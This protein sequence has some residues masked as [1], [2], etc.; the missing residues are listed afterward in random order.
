MASEWANVKT[1]IY[2][3][4]NNPGGRTAE[5]FLTGPFGF[6]DQILQMA[7]YTGV[8]AASPLDR[9][10]TA[11]NATNSGQLHT[12]STPATVQGRELVI[13]SLMANIATS[14]S[15]PSDGFTEI[16]DHTIAWSSLATAVHERIVTTT[17][18][19]GHYATVADPG[20]DDTV[21]AP[22]GEDDAAAV[23]RYRESRCER[24][25]LR[26]G[27]RKSQ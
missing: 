27:N 17:G 12:G 7:E 2:Y 8:A 14:F 23:R 1:S 10:A 18:V 15:A 16:H 22:G 11:G 4:P 24:S 21:G 13:T 19:Y 26:W 6:R 25:G 20:A 5:T 9:T 3:Y